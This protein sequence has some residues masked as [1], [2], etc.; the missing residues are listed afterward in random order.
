MS[1]Q[2]PTILFIGR[3][4]RGNQLFD[5]VEPMDWWVYQPQSANEA[6][7]MYVSYLPDVVLMDAEAAP[8]MVEEVYYHLAPIATEP[9]I[10]IAHDDGWSDRVTYHLPAQADPMEI[11]EFVAK[12]TNADWQPETAQ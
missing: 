10:V 2:H 11:I 6:L 1:Y 9:I 5:I 3:G 12:I 8:E 7:G 4:E